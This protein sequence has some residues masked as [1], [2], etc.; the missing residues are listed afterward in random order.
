MGEGLNKTKIRLSPTECKDEERKCV[1]KRTNCDGDK[2]LRWKQSWRQ[3]EIR[4]SR[5]IYE[6]QVPEDGRNAEVEEV[7]TGL[8]IRVYTR[9]GSLLH[10]A[11]CIWMEAKDKWAA[12]MLTSL[13]RL[14]WTQWRHTRAE[15]NLSKN[16]KIRKTQLHGRMLTWYAQGS[17]F[18]P[19]RAKK[20]AKRK[21]LLKS[22]R[23]RCADIHCQSQHVEGRHM[24][25]SL[26]SKLVH[27]VSLRLT[28][29]TYWDPTPFFLT[30]DPFISF[31][32][33]LYYY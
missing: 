2:S 14:P 29:N 25:I 33:F 19:S 3:W 8:K 17:G 15:G 21:G 32:H 7:L 26:S 10:R 12:E 11:P 9:N 31:F 13:L 1:E 30:W 6:H 18:M 4:K 28:R 22:P 24:Q 20:H 16:A 23:A 5:K 27:M